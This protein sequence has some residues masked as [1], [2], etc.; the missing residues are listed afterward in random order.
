MS[1][2]IIL[3]LIKDKFSDVNSLD[4]FRP[5]MSSSE[6]L[7]LL[8]YII[9]HKLEGY[10][11]IND[12]QHGFNSGN[13]TATAFFIFKETILNQTLLFFALSLISVKRLT[14]WII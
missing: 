6:I 8:E 3:P 2:G 7:K 9:L 10:F 14:A 11:D 1:N 12:R 5:I 4:N 13:S